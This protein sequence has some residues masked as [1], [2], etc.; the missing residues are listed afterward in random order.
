MSISNKTLYTL[1]I[2]STKFI[3]IVIAVLYIINTA[4]SYKGYDIEEL[5]MIG[6]MSLIPLAKLYLDSFTFKLCLHHRIFIYY[7]FAHNLISNVDYYTDYR[8]IDNRELFLI[9]LVLFGIATI[10][11]IIFKRKYDFSR[12][13]SSKAT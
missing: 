9:H 3:P 13:R 5:A 2:K 6:G 11:Y 12:K 4:L 8:L 1:E 10:L 7:V